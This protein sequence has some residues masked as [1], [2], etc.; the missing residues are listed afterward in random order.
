MQDNDPKHTSRKTRSFFEDSRVTLW[1][2]PPDCKSN[3]EVSR[4]LLKAFKDFGQ[5]LMQENA[6]VIST[7]CKSYS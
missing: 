1:P 3:Q 6:V 5:L 2:T 4:N 7:I